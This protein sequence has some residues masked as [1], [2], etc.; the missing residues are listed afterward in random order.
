LLP[1]FQAR[2]ASFAAIII[3]FPATK[4]AGQIPLGDKTKKHHKVFFSYID[5]YFI[6]GIIM[7]NQQQNIGSDRDRNVDR[8]TV[9]S[10]DRMGQQSDT[11][12]QSRIND[13]SGSSGSNKSSNLGS[14]FGSSQG[15]FYRESGVGG[16]Q[17]SGMSQFG[18]KMQQGSERIQQGIRDGSERLQQGIQQG[19]DKLQQGLG[20]MGFGGKHGQ[21]SIAEQGGQQLQSQQGREHPSREAEDSTLTTSRDST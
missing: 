16:Q 14:Q 11:Q 5:T 21:S 19:Q 6:T 10:T 9:G 2:N 12:G 15:T 13:S 7:S 1:A 3:I 8:T 17:R 4:S 18:D 20:G